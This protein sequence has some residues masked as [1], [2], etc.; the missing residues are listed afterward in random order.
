MNCNAI[1]SRL[2][3]YL[4][5]ELSGH[6][7][8]TVRNHVARCSS[9]AAELESLRQTKALLGS[10]RV[11][12]PM[13]SPDE[14]LRK[15]RLADREVPRRWAVGLIAASAVCA[16]LVALSMTRDRG[17]SNSGTGSSVS[18]SAADA[19]YTYSGDT[20]AGGLPIVPAAYSGD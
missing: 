3:S 5:G 10:V 11:P 19:P 2:S 18:V 8:L 20:L 6:E 17:G 13:S 16:G 14:M 1:E 9:C 7:S 4:D 15:I 12:D